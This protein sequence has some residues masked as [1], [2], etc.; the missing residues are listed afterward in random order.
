MLAGAGWHDA[1]VP[2]LVVEIHVPLVADRSVREGDY[3]YRW[4]DAIEDHIAELEEAGEVECFDV[5]EEL[6]E[7]YVFFITGSTEALLL[8]AASEIISGKGVPTGAYAVVTDDTA[9]MG[10]GR[11]VELTSIHMMEPDDA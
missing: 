3:R 4:I 6:G 8:A 2:Q 1:S 7:D 11:R 9:D 10:Q 5:G